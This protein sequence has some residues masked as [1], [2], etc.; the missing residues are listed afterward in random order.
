MK[1]ITKLIESERE[2]QDAL[3]EIEEL[4]DARPGTPDSDRL[5]LLAKLVE[6]YEKERISMSAPDPI[7]AIKF[8]MEQVGLTRKDL[9]PLL[10]SRS[11]VAEVLNGQR[12]LS[13]AMI[14]NLHANLGIPLESLLQ[15]QLA[16]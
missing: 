4:W 5:N 16:R 15:P 10:G 9:E 2:R 3:R 13:K 1:R 7:T 8:R 14:R 6:L 12:E 11:K